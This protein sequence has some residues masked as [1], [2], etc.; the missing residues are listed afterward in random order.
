MATTDEIRT[1][2]QT[3]V[4][5]FSANDREGWL[6]LFSADAT[7]EDPVG[8]DVR[9]GVAEIGEF[10]DFVHSLADSAAL[11]LAEPVKAVGHEAAFAIKVITEMGGARFG[12]DVID[13]MTFDEDAKI[14]SM[15]AFWEMSEMAPL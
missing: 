9:N 13:V 7:L 10:W 4:E 15:R 5:R 14:T 2:I 6:A 12:V 1:T 8:T 3:Y 11:E